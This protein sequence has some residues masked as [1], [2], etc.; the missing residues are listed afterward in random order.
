MS[1]LGGIFSPK[2]MGKQD[3][4]A[5]A[6]K[7]IESGLT[8]GDFRDLRKRAAEG[9]KSVQKMIPKAQSQIYPSKSRKDP[10]YSV[11]EFELRKAIKIPVTF[12]FGEKPPV[13]LVPGTGSTG[14]LTYVGNYLKLLANVPYADPVWLDIPD[15]LLDDAQKNAVS[16]CHGEAASI[17]C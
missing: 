10:S 13:I 5:R 17:M 1:K 9:D 15:F 16:N 14:F 4:H 12:T 7:L 3:L 8:T 11:W 6:M 2:L